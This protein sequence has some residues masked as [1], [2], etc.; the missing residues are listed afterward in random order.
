[1]S[2]KNIVYSS[3][4][5]GVISGAVYGLFQQLAV[6]PIIY[7]AEVFEISAQPGTPTESTDNH[8][9]GSG[10][11]H[12]AVA[13]EIGGP[14]NGLQRIAS[15]FISNILIS[16]SF[17]MIMIAAMAIHNQKSTKRPVDWKSGILWGLSALLAVYVSPTLLGIHPEIPGTIGGLLKDHQIWWITCC[18]S[19]LLGLAFLYYANNWLKLGGFALLVAPHIIGA[20]GPS[21]PRY[22]NT[23]PAAIAALNQLTGEF[24]IMTSIG[25]LIFFILI[26]ALS[27]LA[28]AR[29]HHA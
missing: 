14:E 29:I 24:L 26:G 15:T 27:G 6:N 3:L 2:F 7:A 22:A 23:D 10:N 20:P 25:M 12:E 1:M 19:T 21:S 17:S 16:M 18:A 13:H 28:S 9:H 5:V 11:S 4:I 8:S